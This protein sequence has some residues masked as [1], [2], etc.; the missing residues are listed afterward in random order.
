MVM[1][2]DGCG[3]E[4]LPDDWPWLTDARLRGIMPLI[5]AVSSRWTLNLEPRWGWHCLPA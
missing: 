3:A 5:S 1:Q 4:L 2:E